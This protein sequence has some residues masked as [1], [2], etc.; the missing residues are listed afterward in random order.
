MHINSDIM[1]KRDVDNIIPNLKK[2]RRNILELTQMANTVIGF[3]DDIV[4]E[5]Q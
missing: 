1:Q 3:T 4:P 5:R 2:I